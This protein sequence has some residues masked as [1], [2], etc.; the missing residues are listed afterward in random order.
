VGNLGQGIWGQT[1]VPRFF[2]QLN[3]QE[4]LVNVPSVPILFGHQFFIFKRRP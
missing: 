2:F 1:G 3:R 4:K